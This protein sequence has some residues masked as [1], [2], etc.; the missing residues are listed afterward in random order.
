MNARVIVPACPP[1]LVIQAIY[2]S[3]LI[4][5]KSIKFNQSRLVLT[6]ECPGYRTGPPALVGYWSEIYTSLL[7]GRK[8]RDLKFNQSRLVLT[9]GLPGYRTGPPPALVGDDPARPPWWLLVRNIY[10]IL[11]PPSFL[12]LFLF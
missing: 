7:I 11:V 2:T 12:I 6:Y 3:L 8:S 9:P 1:W 10:N 4:G 5:R